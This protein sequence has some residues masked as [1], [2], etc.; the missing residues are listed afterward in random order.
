MCVCVCVTTYFDEEE[1]DAVCPQR[2]SQFHV[3]HF[4]FDLRHFPTVVV[5]LRVGLNTYS[6]SEQLVHNCEMS[7]VW[8][9]S[10]KK[11]NSDHTWNT[12]FSAPLCFMYSLGRNS[13]RLEKKWEK[14]HKKLK[15]VEKN[16]TSS[17]LLQPAKQINLTHSRCRIYDTKTIV[18][19]TAFMTGWIL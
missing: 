18:S 11:K 8:S 15:V 10:F 12:F 13:F 7:R 9:I 2:P 6:A 4:S 14:K 5:L 3:F 1:G 16:M 17:F 19:I